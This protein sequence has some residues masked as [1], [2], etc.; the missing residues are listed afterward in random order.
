MIRLANVLIA[1]SDRTRADSLSDRLLR[2]GYRTTIV[3]SAAE[4]SG[5]V[6]G[7]CPDLVMVGEGLHPALLAIV[8]RNEGTA[9]IP[10]VLVADAITPALCVEAFDSGCDDAVAAACGDEELFARLLPLV[11]LATMHAELRQRALAARRFGVAARQRVTAAPTRPNVLVVGDD[12][13]PVQAVLAAEADITCTDNLFEAEDLLTRRNFDAAV[14]SFS[15]E[16]NRVLDF[17][18]QVR[19]NP[20]LFN[21]PILLLAG[22][23]PSPTEAYRH[24]ATRVLPRPVEPQVLRTGVLT[25]VRRQ[26][27]R[28]AIRGALAES[29]VAQTRDDDTGCYSRAY[30]EGY[31]EDR[32]AL[33]EAS[34][35]YL[36][37]VELT[38]PNVENVR[39]EFGADAGQHLTQQLG[40]WITGLLRAED[41]VARTGSHEFS[42]VLPDTPL[43]EA[44]VVMHRIAGVL[45]YTDFAV[46]EVY[47]PVKA[48]VQVGATEA[49]PG[50]DI[51]AVL[52]RVRR[53]LG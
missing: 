1:D 27:L 12:P 49:R 41:L 28:W 17:C 4:A 31:L 23:A 47:Q 9:D 43:A 11:R 36:T 40:Q 21:L 33:A 45:A 25:L 38:A 5:H 50:D 22:Y 42:A 44:E 34:G 53:N 13:A 26:Q 51:A 18:T 15:G 16:E 52:A 39:R 19:H 29:L 8:D 14:L 46:R 48:W 10:V 6:G 35:R 7:E 3:A 24:G 37:V 2:A 20:R 32:L 30:Y